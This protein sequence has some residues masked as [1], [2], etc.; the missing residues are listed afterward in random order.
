M[1]MC[2]TKEVKISEIEVGQVFYIRKEDEY[3][4]CTLEEKDFGDGS[5]RYSRKNGD[6]TY[7]EFASPNMTVYLISFS[8]IGE[9][10]SV[11]QFRV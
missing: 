10:P 6:Y 4:P 7:D 5:I 1:D 3:F 9:F 11:P 8:P 2:S